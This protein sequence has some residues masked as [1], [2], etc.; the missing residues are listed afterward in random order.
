[1]IALSPIGS[2]ATAALEVAEI[3][4]RM[5]AVGGA[6]AG[7]AS[8]WAETRLC[9]GFDL[10]PS[11]AM[12]G[13]QARYPSRFN[14]R[15]DA[16][17]ATAGGYAKYPDRWAKSV[18]CMVAGGSAKWPYR[19]MVN[20]GAISG[21]QGIPLVNSQWKYLWGLVTAT[22]GGLLGGHFPVEYL[23]HSELMLQHTQTTLGFTMT[24]TTK[25]FTMAR[26]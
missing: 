15:Q 2:V 19:L 10:P 14:S 5:T 16:S 9:I 1:M 24:N 25:K 17:G 23:L 8:V 21:I 26:V 12:A 3:P 20:G 6:F 7:G 22:G 11:G 13:G 18:T 4:G